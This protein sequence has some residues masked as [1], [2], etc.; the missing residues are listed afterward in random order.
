MKITKEFKSNAQNRVGRFTD[1]ELEPM[2]DK[3][4]NE[5]WREGLITDVGNDQGEFFF[6]SGAEGVD[7][8]YAVINGKGIRVSETLHNNPEACEI[9][10]M[11]IVH[12]I[13][14]VP[15]EGEGM[16]Y[17]RLATASGYNLADSVLTVEAEPKKTQQPQRTPAK[18]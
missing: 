1:A 12:G 15:G 16:P 4:L 18:R 5:C 13:S 11:R 9:G 3:S 17:W 2:K 7:A 8:T 6:K 14:N 10:D